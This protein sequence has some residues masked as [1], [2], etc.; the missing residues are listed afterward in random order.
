MKILYIFAAGLLLGNSAVL[1]AEDL[2]TV[3]QQALE[4]DPELKS[5]AIKVDIGKDQ[6]GQ[7]FGEMLPQVSANANWS[8]NNSRSATKCIPNNAR[9]RCIA[10]DQDTANYHGTRYM[11]SVNQSLI[12]FAKFWNWRRA[13]EIE[14]QYQSENVEAQHAL[15]FNVV[16][17]Y[18]G[19]LEAG[20]QLKFYQAE[21]ESTAQQLEQI[22]RLYEKQMVKITDLY[23]VEAR[24]DQLRATKIE[25]ETVLVT[26]K[27]NLKALTDSEPTTLLSLREEIEFKPLEGSL[28]EWIGVAKSEN[29]TLAAQISAIAAAS[30]D[31]AV[32]KSRYLPVVDLQFNYY[33]TNTGF[34]SA[35]TS[36]TEVQVAAINV[37]VPIFNGGVTTHR[38]YEAK[39]KLSLSQIENEAKIR[40]LI[41][42][43]SDAFLSANA[44]VRRIQASRKSV[45]SASKSQQAM[46]AGFSYGVE[47]MND[48][49]IA[50]QLEFKAK[51]ELSQ[52]KYSYIKNRIRFMRAV[53]LISEENLHEVNDWLQVS[54]DGSKTGT[55]DKTPK[56]PTEK[57]VKENQL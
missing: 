52:A 2:L 42:E 11:L 25:A 15:M 4:A 8:A 49:L 14:N 18:F 51:R 28:E 12:D 16:D 27:E 33:D 29:P 9:T 23:E 3:Y 47:T 19:V 43:T 13:Q 41:K 53:G 32:Q 39:H 21:E 10:Y 5:A 22:Q 57:N 48:V 1:H 55:F 17:K 31:V 36:Q 6:K 24:L 45:E 44:S 7:A 54:V 30:D 46:Q 20:D 40:A 35:R 56:T 38:M 50:Q 34:Q 26:A 37:S